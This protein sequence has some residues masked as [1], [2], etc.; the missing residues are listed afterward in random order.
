MGRFVHFPFRRPLAP[1]AVAAA[2]AL[3]AVSLAPAASGEYSVALHFQ[4]IDLSGFLARQGEREG[5]LFA[6]INWSQLVTHTYIW[7]SH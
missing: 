2:V 7:E 4:T 6:G 5:V 3:A 1:S